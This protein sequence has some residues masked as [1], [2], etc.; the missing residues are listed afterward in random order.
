MMREEVLASRYQ[1]LATTMTERI[2]NLTFYHWWP[3][4]EILATG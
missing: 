1:I 3:E 2:K 4:P